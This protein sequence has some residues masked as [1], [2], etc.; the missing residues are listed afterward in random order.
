MTAT[1]GPHRAATLVVAGGIAALLGLSACGSQTPTASSVSDPH[2]GDPQ[3]DEHG[4]TLHPSTS[5]S[6]EAEPTRALPAIAKQ[7]QS[8]PLSNPGKPGTLMCNQIFGIEVVKIDYDTKD[9]A[10]RKA[11]RARPPKD[12]VWILVDFKVHRFTEAPA[13]HTNQTAPVFTDVKDEL[14]RVGRVLSDDSIPGLGTKE[15]RAVYTFERS[16]AKRSELLFCNSFLSSPAVS[17]G[18]SHL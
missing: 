2:H 12:P 1:R 15:Y 11:W 6:N 5:A 10:A 3:V 9:P 7:C 17:E 18:C 13:L 8:H 14:A 4:H 16:E